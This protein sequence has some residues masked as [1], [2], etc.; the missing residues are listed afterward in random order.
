MNK[1]ELIEALT[2]YPDDSEVFAYLQS[3]YYPITGVEYD[4]DD[5]IILTTNED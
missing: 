3:I 1:A 4:Q 5:C 2:P